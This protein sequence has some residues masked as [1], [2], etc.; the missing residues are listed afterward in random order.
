MQVKFTKLREDA[1]LPYRGHGID[2]G[3]DCPVPEAG[4]LVPGPNKIPMGW[5]VDVPV[6]YSASM[7]PRSGMASGEKTTDLYLFVQHYTTEPITVGQIHPHG[8]AITAELPPID[9]GY[10][11]EVHAIVINHSDLYIK[12]KAGT[13]FSQLVFHPIAYATPVE[14]IDNSRGTGAFGSTGA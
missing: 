1:I 5:A 2:V 3:L 8:V 7:Y 6:G 14:N 4:I 10:K 12:Y 11:G 13:R 9:P